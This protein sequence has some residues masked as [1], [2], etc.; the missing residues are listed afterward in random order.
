MSFPRIGPF[1]LIVV[2]VIVL[3]VFGVGKLPQIGGA[4]GKAMREFRKTQR[5]ED[6]EAEAAGKKGAAAEDKTPSEEGRTRPDK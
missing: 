3:I 4:I 6:E 1:E 2:L 5:G